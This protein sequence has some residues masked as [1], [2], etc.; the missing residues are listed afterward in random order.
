VFCS[1][2]C[3]CVCVCVG[4]GAQQGEAKFALLAFVQG[5]KTKSSP[6]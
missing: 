3:V 5:A 2:V 1:C 6:C 4:G